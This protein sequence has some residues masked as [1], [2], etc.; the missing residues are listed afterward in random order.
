[1]GKTKNKSIRKVSKTLNT[2]NIDFTKSFDRNKKMLVGLS[3]GKKLRNQIAG[4]LARTRKQQQ[5]AE[6]KLKFSKKE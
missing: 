1:M 3:I 5:K 6:E 2:S 4:L